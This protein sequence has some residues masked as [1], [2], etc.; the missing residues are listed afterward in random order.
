M[1]TN[2]IDMFNSKLREYGSQ[3]GVLGPDASDMSKTF[4][5][6]E[7]TE[8]NEKK[9]SKSYLKDGITLSQIYDLAKNKKL[10]NNKIK[11][12]IKKLLND[13]EELYDFL[14]SF[15]RSD[16]T[17]KEE[18]KEAT[19]SGGSG[20]YEA[21]LFSN[22]KKVETKE[23]TGSSSSGSYESPS[24]LA[25]SMSKKDWRGKSKTQLPG[26]KFV[27][28]KKKCKKFPYCNQGDIKAL[29]IFENDT[30]KGVIQKVSDR[31][32]LHEDHIKDIILNEMS[33]LT[34]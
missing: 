14:N 3:A 30:L 17:K 4:K 21:P 20:G 18:S 9:S 12:E 32:D 19:G 34:K 7:V 6:T 13:P 16:D 29:N 5:A 28:V 11:S 15:K 26:G 10:S 31:Y 25:K 24:F 33:K 22:I 1:E 8:E 2:Y 23:A 27:Q